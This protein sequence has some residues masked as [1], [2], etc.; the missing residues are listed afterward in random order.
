MK[1]T[2]QG[3]THLA[4]RIILFAILA[5]VLLILF[6]LLR[7]N[8]GTKTG[9]DAD[10]INTEY[11]TEE[12]DQVFY[13]T[14]ED[15][16]TVATAYDGELRILFLG[17]DMLSDGEAGKRI[18]DLIGTALAQHEGIEDEVKVFN[19]AVP[20]TRVAPKTA[21]YN[22][23]YPY[24][25]ASFLYVAGYIARDDYAFLDRYA[26][27]SGDPVAREAVETLTNLA[28]EQLDM[29]VIGYDAIDYLM[30]TPVFNPGNDYDPV[31]YCGA[32]KAGINVIHERYPHI[33]FVFL[34]PTYCYISDE[35]GD[36]NSSDIVD[37]GNGD[38]TTYLI[39]A[40]D[41]CQSEGVS[42]IDNYSGTV[43]ADN[44]DKML[45]DNIHLTDKARE[46]IAAH[47]MRVIY[48]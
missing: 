15:L 36:L 30:G 12:L 33:R 32:L 26:T 25:L 39:K 35:D 14:D 22:A 4:G 46:H 5:A 8:K 6:L 40:I 1:K 44:A 28:F 24:D 17:N 7:W 38:L 20:A 43:D 19:A 45:T 21:E 3:K 48:P 27:D 9:F 37:I 34:S 42:I 10:N 41:V 18:P 31:A 23:L 16:A 47:F 2:I 13:V 29:I 11:E